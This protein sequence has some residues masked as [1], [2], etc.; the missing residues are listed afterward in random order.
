MK[1][2]E[3]EKEGK[4]SPGYFPYRLRSLKKN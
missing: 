3:R 4:L 1:I 2:K